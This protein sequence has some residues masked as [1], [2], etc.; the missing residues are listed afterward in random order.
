MWLLSSRYTMPKCRSISPFSSSARASVCGTLTLELLNFEITAQARIAIQVASENAYAHMLP[1]I[2][3]Y[4]FVLATRMFCVYVACVQ[5]H[6]ITRQQWFKAYECARWCESTRPCTRP[7][8]RRDFTNHDA[9]C[10]LAWPRIYARV[11]VSLCTVGCTHYHGHRYSYG[12]TDVRTQI[13]HLLYSTQ[14]HAHRKRLV[15]FDPARFTTLL[16]R[17]IGNSQSACEEG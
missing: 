8:T 16:V 1:L 11:L 7:H 3:A 10:C 2:G 15:G 13:L 5:L 14:T 9:R 6:A 12:I 4:V 17:M